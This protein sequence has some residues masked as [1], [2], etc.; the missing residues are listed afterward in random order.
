MLNKTVPQFGRV[1][2][3]R[4]AVRHLVLVL[5][6]LAFAVEIF[7]P[8]EAR[9][10][11]VSSRSDTLTNSVISVTSNHTIIFTAQNNITSA[12][13]A[14]ASS[15]VS[16]TFPSDFNLSTFTCNDVDL[17]VAGTAT[18]LNVSNGDGHT[19]CPNTATSWGVNID[20]AN[21]VILFTS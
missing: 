18:S 16:V 6:G 14:S 15:N 20:S 21:R 9:A 2:A 4:L 1:G 11:Q 19:N 5:F 3:R 7:V 12:G 17:S 10:N 13:G 8:H